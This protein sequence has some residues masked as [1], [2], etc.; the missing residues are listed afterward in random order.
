MAYIFTPQANT[1]L[2]KK[3]N[4]LR[5][6]MPPVLLQKQEMLFMEK[7]Y[8]VNFVNLL[9]NIGQKQPAEYLIGLPPNGNNSATV[10]EVP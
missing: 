1:Y 10:N 9:Y 4:H 5:I 2:S 6:L 8:S 3:A 7:V